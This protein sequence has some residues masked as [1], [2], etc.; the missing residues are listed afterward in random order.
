MKIK[1]LGLAVLATL[2][3]S[4]A[5]AAPAG[6]WALGLGW[7]NIDPV[8]DYSRLTT[9]LP[10]VVPN[11]DVNV[12]SQF[13]P[14]VTAEYFL[15]NNL[16]V[17]LVAALP[18]KHEIYAKGLGL[19]ASTKHLPPTVTFQYHFDLP[20]TKFKPFIGAGVNYTIF[21]DEKTVGKLNGKDL[22]I[23]DSVGA[24]ARLGL[25][26]QFNK[27]QAIRADVRWI[28]ISPDVVVTNADNTVAATGTVDIDPLVYGLSYVHTF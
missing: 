1:A 5:S 8:S 27:N 20:N 7:H 4:A 12:D 11:A 24:S 16:G 10:G 18:F 22:E 28:D 15:M 23:D 2:G 3:M 6:S 26:Y 25:D 13:G 14:T 19:V 21:F 17:E 9:K